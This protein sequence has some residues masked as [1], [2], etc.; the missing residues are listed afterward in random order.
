MGIIGNHRDCGE[1]MG[2]LG[3][4]C[5]PNA[6]FY[7]SE[8]VKVLR[9]KNIYRTGLERVVSGRPWIGQQQSHRPQAAEL[10]KNN[11]H[12]LQ[13][14]SATPLVILLAISFLAAS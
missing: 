14:R 7:D 4:I 2:M 12:T 13:Q 9:Y 1:D 10:L 5:P 8:F 6:P 3:K 11:S